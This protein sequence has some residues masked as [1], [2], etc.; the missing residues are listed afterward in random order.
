MPLNDDQKITVD[1]IKDLLGAPRLIRG[2]SE[3]AYDKALHVIAEGE[4][5]LATA[6]EKH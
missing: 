3:E 2:E 1:Q 5:K 6:G 4:A